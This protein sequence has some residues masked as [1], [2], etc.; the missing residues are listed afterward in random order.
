MKIQFAIS[1]STA[2][3]TSNTL[4]F[5]CRES[6]A[7]GS[8]SFK[9]FPQRFNFDPPTLKA[10]SWVDLQTKINQIALGQKAVFTEVNYDSM[11]FAN[12]FIQH[13]RCLKSQGKF[14]NLIDAFQHYLPDAHGEIGFNNGSHCIGLSQEICRRDPFQKT[15]LA[16][17]HYDQ[18]DLKHQFL[19]TFYHGAAV[20][21][22]AVPQVGVRE[23]L[24]GYT[25]FELGAS[26]GAFISVDRREPTL[27][28]HG[29][30]NWM[31]SLV[32]DEEGK[33]LIRWEVR[34][35]K[36]D[37][38]F[39]HYIKTDEILNP[40]ESTTR[41]VLAGLSY[42]R[43]SRFAE[44]G[45]VKAAITIDLRCDRQT[46]MLQLR[47]EVKWYRFCEIEQA[48]DE[49]KCEGRFLEICHI[50]EKKPHS[51]ENRIRDLVENAAMMQEL[52]QALHG[53]DDDA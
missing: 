13:V 40:D 17:S 45:K 22:W 7:L 49:L 30:Q 5:P 43:L 11:I 19:P 53:P 16:T 9:F 32:Q 36:S 27:M 26:K 35:D 51:L 20:L 8:H 23:D 33:D 29:S 50:L 18:H 52:R 21:K 24:I 39:V 14:S 25:L 42:F 4:A 10:S 1:P 28:K 46:I 44:S 38:Y 31:I 37:D 48:I 34:F 41:D 3:F 12:R 6:M 15:Y 47:E 2:G